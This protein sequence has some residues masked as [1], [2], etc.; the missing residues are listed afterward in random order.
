MMAE[1]EQDRYRNEYYSYNQHYEQSQQYVKSLELQ[2]CQHRDKI[3][4][5]NDIA[6]RF[7]QKTEVPEST[8]LYGN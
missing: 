3:S 7:N 6:Q 1:K 8:L 4:R 5:L 2:G